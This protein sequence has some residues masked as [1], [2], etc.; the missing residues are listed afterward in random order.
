MRSPQIERLRAARV[1]VQCVCL[2]IALLMVPCVFGE[3]SSSKDKTVDGAKR[4]KWLIDGSVVDSK[5]EQPLAEFIVTPGTL[6]VDDAGRTTVRWRDNLKI[7][8][9][10]GRFQWPRTSGFSEMRF[11]VSA[12]GYR[13]LVTP[14]MRRGGPYTRIRVRLVHE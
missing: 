2:A 8:M 9:R 7:V 14:A 5:S 4:M 13:A 12:K 10:E 1:G 6:S 3:E 11:R